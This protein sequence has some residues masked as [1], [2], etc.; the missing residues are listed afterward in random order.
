VVERQWLTNV[1]TLNIK[2]KYQTLGQVTKLLVE[3][4]LPV[5]GTLTLRGSGTL[6]MTT[7]SSSGYLSV[8]LGCEQ[9]NP[10]YTLEVEFPEI[11]EQPLLF[12][13]TPSM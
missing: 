3:A 10:I 9:L 12:V 2:V 1:G 13:I 5:K 11:D 7:S 4:D 8:E 6:A